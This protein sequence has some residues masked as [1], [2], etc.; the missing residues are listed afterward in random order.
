VNEPTFQVDWSRLQASWRVERPRVEL[1]PTEALAAAA[2]R[3]EGAHAAVDYQPGGEALKF[4]YSL[5]A[6]RSWLACV[7]GGS[8]R[9]QARGDRLQVTVAASPWPLLLYAAFGALAV[10]MGHL[11][12]SWLVG[13]VALLLGGNYLFVHFGLWSVAQAVA[14][15]P[16]AA[17]AA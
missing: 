1:S 7:S 13:V 14:S 2:A 11:G 4:G 9:T 10:R 16:P 15:T 6:G 12:T 3:L 8:V 5:R 17:R